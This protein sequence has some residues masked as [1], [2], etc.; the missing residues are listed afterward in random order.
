MHV[1]ERERRWHR[2]PFSCHWFPHS[3][4]FFHSVLVA[5]AAIHVACMRRAMPRWLCLLRATYHHPCTEQLFVHLYRH[6]RHG[7][8]QAKQS[9]VGARRPCH[10]HA[11]GM[12]CTYFATIM[13]LPQ[14]RS[15]Y[16][17]LFFWWLGHRW[18]LL[19]FGLLQICC[20]LLLLLA[21]IAL[22]SARWGSFLGSP[23]KDIDGS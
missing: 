18:L 14:I 5:A 12:L 10:C 13:M 9:A 1:Q 23:R 21:K 8:E 3:N 4:S 20:V 2:R 7:I 16:L 19:V 6:V 22:P 15:F 11:R 17:I